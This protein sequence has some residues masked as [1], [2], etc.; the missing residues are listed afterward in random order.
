MIVSVTGCRTCRWDVCMITV[1]AAPCL[2]AREQKLYAE[3]AVIPTSS[4][5]CD[6]CEHDWSHLSMAMIYTICE[7]FHTRSNTQ[8]VALG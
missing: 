6:G 2:K 5:S 1:T 4:C 8:S 7:R 3:C